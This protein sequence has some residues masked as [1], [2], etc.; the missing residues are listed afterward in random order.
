MHHFYN[1]LLG[2]TRTLLD[3]SIGGALM[4]KSTNEAY[5][6]LENMA[7]NNCQWPSERVTPKKPDGVH[8]L[9][10]FN[11]LTVQVSLLTKKLQ[12]T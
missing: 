1:G 7:F 2:T 12:S 5:Q 8:K 6:L 3:T 9:D 11:N 4:S 10:V